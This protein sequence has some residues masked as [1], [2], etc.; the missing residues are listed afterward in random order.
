MAY[1][2]PTGNAVNFNFTAGYAAPNGSA[3]DFI[4]G[5]ITV[6]A[7]VLISGH[8]SQVPIGSEG[9]YRPLILVNGIIKQRAP[10]GTEIPLILDAG[11]IRQAHSNETVIV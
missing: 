5:G 7:L 11:T 8:R 3:V 6:R 10:A 4:L 2:P 9:V 1:T